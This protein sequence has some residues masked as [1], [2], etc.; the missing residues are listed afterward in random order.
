MTAP[1]T[2]IEREVAEI[3]AQVLGVEHVGIHDNFF[4]LGGDSLLSIQ[5]IARIEK[6]FGKTLPV[7][8]LFQSPTIE[9]LAT[10]LG[11]ERRSETWSS[12]IP[13]HPAGALLPFFWIHGDS[14]N[15]RL[16][17]Y[18]GPDRPLYAL[19]H[20]AHDG[21]PALLYRGGDHHQPL[22]EGS[23]PHSS[24][25]TLPAGWLFVWCGRRV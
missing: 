21:R 4:D 7:A 3:W 13:V 6:R 23:A 5:L 1:R 19:E 15:A 9:Q 8:V 18:L 2:A 17:E 14:S 22:P 20:Q 10:I 16:P 25:R 12:L 24:A 11:D